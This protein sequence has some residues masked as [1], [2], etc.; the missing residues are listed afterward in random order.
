VLAVTAL[1]DADELLGYAVVIRDVTAQVRAEAKLRSYAEELARSNRDLEQFAA[2]ASH[3]LKSPITAVIGYA[4]MLV[5]H[6]GLDER[7]REW[8][9]RIRDSASRMAEVVDALLAYARA[10]QGD[11]RP[12][13]V[14]LGSAVTTALQALETSLREF[15]ADVRV[16]L[17]PVVVGDPN[18]LSLLFQNLIGNAV[19]FR[20]PARR[21]VVQVQAEVCDGGW[22]ITVADNGIGIP[23][24][25]VDEVFHMFTRSPAAESYPGTG[26]G[27]AIC[28]RIVLR[29][30]GRIWVDTDRAVGTAFHFTLPLAELADADQAV[31]ALPQ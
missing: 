20:D 26:I 18:L 16:G 10:D 6:A 13:T 30:G 31:A 25:E 22:L 24:D 5:R 11:F 9:A 12:Q 29:H 14:D 17:L 27:L 8:V 4:D 28:E 1:T 7:S 23:P 3:D 21:P 2:T 19:K 15:G